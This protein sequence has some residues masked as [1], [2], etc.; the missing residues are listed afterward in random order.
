MVL[1]IAISQLVVLAAIIALAWWRRRKAGRSTYLNECLF[2]LLLTLDVTVYALYGNSLKGEV[3]KQW[4][5][6][7]PDGT[8]IVFFL[9]IGV[10]YAVVIG[11][12]I[13]LCRY[14][15][16]RDKQNLQDGKI[17]R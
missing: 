1:A 3:A 4:Q 11:P 7:F 13:E 12:F 2:W 5:G 17:G 15:M 8:F 14:L 9:F 16:K 10:V 6:D